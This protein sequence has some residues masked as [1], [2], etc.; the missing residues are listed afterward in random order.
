MPGQFAHIVQAEM[1]LQAGEARSGM[2]NCPLAP[3]C[4]PPLDLCS[5]LPVGASY[6][7]PNGSLSR[8][9]SP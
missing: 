9:S 5:P 6:S 8:S 7:P 2:E 1:P 4:V 3:R